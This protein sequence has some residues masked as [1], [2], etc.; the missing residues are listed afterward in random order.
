[1]TTRGTHYDADATMAVPQPHCSRNSLYILFSTN[2][3]MSC[4]EII[5][6]S[7]YIR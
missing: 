3:I 4:R 5:S 7:P 6:S 1:M 2:G